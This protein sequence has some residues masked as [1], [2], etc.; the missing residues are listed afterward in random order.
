MP[1]VTQV[2]MG[3]LWQL[4]QGHLLVERASLSLSLSS[5]A[6]AQLSCQSYDSEDWSFPIHCCLLHFP[7]QL[8]F[9]ACHSS[10]LVVSGPGQ[11]VV[12][13]D[14]TLPSR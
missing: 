2:L 7:P 10:P 13:I 8:C 6:P 11:V 14:F 3:L 12:S 9:T 1:W 5:S 4:A